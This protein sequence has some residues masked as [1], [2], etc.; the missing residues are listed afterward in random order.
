MWFLFVFICCLGCS[1]GYS[2]KGLLL[3]GTIAQE[4]RGSPP[5]VCLEEKL[6][7]DSALRGSRDERKKRWSSHVSHRRVRAKAN[8]FIIIKLAYRKFNLGFWLV[9]LLFFFS[10]LFQHALRVCRVR[11]EGAM[12]IFF[13]VGDREAPPTEVTG[14]FWVSHGSGSPHLGLFLS[15]DGNR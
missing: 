5:R 14:R 10:T 12:S 2:W 8:T 7:S 13:H 6:S 3:F 4:Q 15:V 1:L 9:G 11:R